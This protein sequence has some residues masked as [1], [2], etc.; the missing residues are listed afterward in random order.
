MEGGQAIVPR[1]G[2]KICFSLGD[3]IGEG[4]DGKAQGE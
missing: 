4:G 2:K 3:A 1:K